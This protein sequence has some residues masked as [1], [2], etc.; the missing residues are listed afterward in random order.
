MWGPVALAVPSGP[1]PVVDALV[2]A[3]LR[4][5]GN[6]EDAL[7]T[8]YTATAVGHIESVTS[9]LLAR[10]E[11]VAEADDWSD[12]DRL[13]VAPV[14]AVSDITYVDVDGVERALSSSTY[15]LRG[16]ALGRGI[17]LEAGEA[18][19]ARQTGSRVT[20][21]M[22]AGYETLPVELTQAALLLVGQWARNRMPINVG[23]IVN[24]L[25]NGFTALIENHKRYLV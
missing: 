20:V 22:D 23:N 17:C 15:R 2:K 25:P 9:T 5:L 11:A 3:H 18:W 7:I 13:P 12:L 14:S 1:G 21:T 16:D 8:H 19:P 10:R 4:D 6:D 24:D